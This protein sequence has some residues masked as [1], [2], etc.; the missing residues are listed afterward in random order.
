MADNGQLADIAAVTRPYGYGGDG[1]GFG[2]GGLWLFAILALM[3]GGGNGFGWGNNGYANG[4]ANAIGYENLATSNE[5]QRGFDNQNTQANQR[6]ILSAVTNGTAQSVAATNQI[7]HDLIGYVG[8]KYSEL[9]RDVLMVNSGIQQSI[10]NQNACCCDTKMLISQT[11]A[12]NRYDALKNTNDIN[13][14]TIGQ[15]QKIL[16]AMAQNKIEALQGRVQQLELDRAVSG[17]VRYPQSMS[18]TA[19]YSPFCNCGCSQFA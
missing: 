14:V 19:G 15:T 7:F 17:V 18:Y 3:M 13:A 11:A 6:E 9:D 1:F 8:D 2:G 10:A 4:F 12:Q 16:D 5:V